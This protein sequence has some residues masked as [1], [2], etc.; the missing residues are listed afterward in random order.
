V[1]DSPRPAVSSR[2][3]WIA[4]VVVVSLAILAGALVVS[5]QGSSPADPPSVTPTAPI[6]SAADQARDAAATRIVRRLQRAVRTGGRSKFIGVSEPGNQVGK[7][8]L[9]YVFANLRR[10][11]VTDFTARYLGADVH[12]SSPGTW[13]ASAEMSWRLRGFHTPPVIQETSLRFATHDGRTYLARICLPRDNRWP[14]WAL[15]PLSVRRHHGVVAVAVGSER[16]RSTLESAEQAREDVRAVIGRLDGSLL[17]IAP[18]TGR[19]FDRLVGVS[20]GSYVNIAAVTTTADGSLSPRSLIT[21]DLNPTALGQLGPVGAQV[22]LSHEATHAAT[23]SVTTALPAWLEEGFADYVALREQNLPRRIV[24]AGLLKQVRGHGP[25]ARLPA[26]AAFLAGAPRGGRAYEA[27]WLACKMIA[28]RYGQ[29]ALV[30]FYQQTGRVGAGPALHRVL[31][32]GPAALTRAW[33]AYLER[34]AGG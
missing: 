6:L 16:A 25:P 22:V 32:I 18:A 13:V 33:R 24:A 14:L 34:L 12:R 17:V 27:A 28:A 26:P 3:A 7:M 10:L 11:M 5:Q 15:G 19:Q 1:T 9:G 29:S 30:H 4:V 20:D 2:V 23:R 31:G 21:V 8:R